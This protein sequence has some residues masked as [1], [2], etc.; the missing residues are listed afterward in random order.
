MRKRRLRRIFNTPNDRPRFDLGGRLADGWWETFERTRRHAIR[1]EGEPV[2]DLDFRATLPRL[3]YIKAGLP[4]PGDN[5]DLYA[6][7]L[8]GADEVRWRPGVK[9]VVN[10][11]L[12]RS[13][14]LTRLPKGTK[15]L[16]PKGCKAASLREAIFKRHA[17]IRDQFEA[18]IGGS[19]TRLESDILVAIL[20]RL[21]DLGIVA[22]P[23]HDGLMVRRRAAKRAASVMREVSKALTRYA[24][25]VKVTPL[26][27]TH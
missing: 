8:G 15:A 21:L 10:A 20:L 23:M 25:P 5:D 7:I 1:I 14:Q 16:L 22:L 26:A 12:W 11:M 4:P 27:A 2:A 24:L 6:G 17:P 18:G 19:L 9:K 3:A 13:T